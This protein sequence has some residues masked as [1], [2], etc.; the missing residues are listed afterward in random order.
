MRII[1]LSTFIISLALSFPASAAPLTYAHTW[2]GEPPSKYLKRGK[3]MLR[4][5]KVDV[6]YL[7][8]A[9]VEFTCGKNHHRNGWVGLA[10]SNTSF[11]EGCGSGS[12]VCKLK[13]PICEI[14]ISTEVPQSAVQ[15]ILNHELGHCGGWSNKHPNA[16]KPKNHFE[17]CI[18]T[19]LPVNK[20]RDLCMMEK[21]APLTPEDEE[22]WDNYVRRNR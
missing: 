18:E 6:Q 13:A 5:K 7:S 11:Y 8:T 14:F 16:Q 21:G 4:E 10:C 12:K 20:I 2:G 19:G 22:A 3:E 1:L 15:N 17:N 9:A